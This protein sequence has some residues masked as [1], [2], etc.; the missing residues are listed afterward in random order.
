MNHLKICLQSFP[1]SAAMAT[2]PP[3][4]RFISRTDQFREIE[5]RDLGT[6]GGQTNHSVVCV[7]GAGG[8]S[9]V[10]R[11][12]S[13]CS[14]QVKTADLCGLQIY[15]KSCK[16]PEVAKTTKEDGLR[17]SMCVWCVCCVSVCVCVCVCLSVYLSLCL[18]LSVCLSVCL[19]VRPCVRVFLCVC[20]C[21]V[22]GACMYT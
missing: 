3:F 1:P 17:L 14:V 20:V 21:G 15:G 10:C 11:R 16:T 19:S 13:P 5:P 6:C 22:C 12:L 8:E 7:Q 4:C 18:S 9:G 2:H